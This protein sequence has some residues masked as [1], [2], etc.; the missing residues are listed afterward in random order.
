MIWELIA[1][2]LNL[3]LDSVDGVRR[4][5]LKGDSLAREGLDEDLHFDEGLENVGKSALSRKRLLKGTVSYLDNGMSS[6]TFRNANL[7]VFD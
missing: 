6:S 7:W 1:R 3:G 5:H 4:L 2:T